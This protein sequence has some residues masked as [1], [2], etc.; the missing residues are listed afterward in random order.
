[1]LLDFLLDLF[2][3]VQEDILIAAE[4]LVVLEHEQ[5]IDLPR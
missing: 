5:V 2:Q 1:V 3:R 4:V